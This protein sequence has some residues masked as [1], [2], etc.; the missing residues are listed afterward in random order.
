MSGEPWPKYVEDHIL[1]PLGMS[2]TYPLPTPGTPGLAV[3]YGR[4]VPGEQRELEPFV[5]IEAER[6][7]TPTVDRWIPYPALYVRV[8]QKTGTARD[9]AIAYEIGHFLTGSHRICDSQET[10]VFR[11]NFHANRTLLD[12]PIGEVPNCHQANRNAV[13]PSAA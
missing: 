8:E 12:F 4:R 9:L 1:K 6:P 3:G 11:R 5:D 10:F 2:S 13:I 7:T